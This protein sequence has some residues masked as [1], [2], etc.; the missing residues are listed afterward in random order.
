MVSALSQG[1]PA[2]GKSWSH[3]YE[4]LFKDYG[5]NDGL[6]SVPGDLKSLY[7]KIDFILDLQKS[8]PVRENLVVAAEQLKR[9]SEDMWQQVFN[10]IQS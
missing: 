5:F 3:K 6:V 8:K 10:C 2:L 9:A 4:M 1:V 7:D